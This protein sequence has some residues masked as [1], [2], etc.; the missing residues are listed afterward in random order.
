MLPRAVAVWAGILV[1]AS[2]NGA[3]RDLLLLA[4]LLMPPWL[5]RDRGLFLEART[6][7]RPM[8]APPRSWAAPCL[9]W[10]SAACSAG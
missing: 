10:P 3:V 9:A 6:R 8:A 5:A 7:R 2:L 1:L 4:T